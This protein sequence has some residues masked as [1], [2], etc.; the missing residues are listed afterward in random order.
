MSYDFLSSFRRLFVLW[1]SIL[2]IS[3]NSL[4]IK[5]IDGEKQPVNTRLDEIVKSRKLR[6]LIDYN[7]IDYFI[8][9]GRPMGYQFE[10][11]NHFADYLGVELELVVEN[12]PRNA[13]ERLKTGDVDLVASELAMSLSRAQEVGFTNPVGRSRSVLVQRK[14]EEKGENSSYIQQPLELGG[15]KVWIPNDRYLIRRMHNLMEEIGDSIKLEV[16]FDKS[17]EELIAMVAA[18]EIPY[19]VADERIAKI[20]TLYNA[21]IDIQVPVS[22]YHNVAWAVKKE[23]TEL[24]GIVNEWLTNFYSSPIAKALAN[25]Y[26]EAKRVQFMAQSSINFVRKGRLSE[27]DESFKKFAKVIDWDWRLLAA[28]A[29]QESKFD[30]KAQSWAGANGIMQLMPET[31]LK[32]GV[33]SLSSPQEHIK[34]GAMYIKW[35]EEQWKDKIPD[36]EERKKFVMA[37]YNVGIGHVFDARRL[38]AKFNRNPNHW[39]DVAFYLKNKANPRYYNDAV[40]YY[41]YCRGDEPVNFVKEIFERYRHYRQL[42]KN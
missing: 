38:A 14:P 10:I 6:A 29:F 41:G 24:L 19:V 15:K 9:R 42:V 26:L 28:L 39:E 16:A 3:C 1:F 30:P 31:A 21:S 20:S 37:S 8:Y 27:Y 12:N 34:A 7:S 18:G 17:Q 2:L 23:E 13:I 11:L 40:V 33:D 32:Y 36:P 4:N 22:F 25:K 35:L 5:I